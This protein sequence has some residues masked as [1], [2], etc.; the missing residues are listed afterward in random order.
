MDGSGS[1]CER[2]SPVP[3]KQ[4]NQELASVVSIYEESLFILRLLRKLFVLDLVK[5]QNKLLLYSSKPR[6]DLLQNFRIRENLIDWKYH[7]EVKITCDE[8]VV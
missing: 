6:C 2:S 5:M 3:R 7:C 1:E 4:G 8:D